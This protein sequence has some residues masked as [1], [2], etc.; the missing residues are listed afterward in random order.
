MAVE[1]D[2]IPM[3]TPCPDFALPGVDGRDY[4]LADFKD[5]PV[6]VVMFIC[7]HCPYVKAIEDRY[8]ALAR[9][10]APKGVQF[11][12]ICANDP[13]DY[14]DDSFASLKARWEQKGYGFPYLHDL[15]QD[16]ARSFKA[17]CTPDLFVYDADRRLAYHGRFDDNWQQP[18]QVQKQ[19]LKA[20]LDTL[21]VGGRPPEAQVPSMGCSIKWSKG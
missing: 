11:V 9:D 21:L 19:E 4:R 10:Y 1:T 12:G 20:A 13:V 3:G 14:P 8:I 18:G 5:S 7:N 16:V 17:V 6:L 2:R 15:S